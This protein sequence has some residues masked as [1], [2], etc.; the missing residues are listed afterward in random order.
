MTTAGLVL[1]GYV[2]GSCP[3]GYWLVR[4]FKHE[5]IRASGSGNIGG[6]NVWRTYG[7]KLGLPVVLLDVAKGFLPTLLGVILVSHLAGLLAGAAAMIGHSRPIFLRFA[8]GGKVI[9]TGGGVLFALA[10]LVAVTG[11]AI[12]ASLF[13]VFGYPSLASIATAIFVPIGAW[14]YGYPR[15]V[16]IFG[17]ATAVVAVIL[18]RGNLRR[19][20]D[21][22]ETRS[23]IALIKR[24]FLRST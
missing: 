24:P 1:L 2:L 8:R 4:I 22:T 14:L 21:G 3:W 12:W 20:R 13:W 11:L 9:A 5:D 10:P 18:H 19:L 6:S 16:L 7:A 23:G 15:P 17:I